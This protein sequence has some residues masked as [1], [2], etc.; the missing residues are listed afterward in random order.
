LAAGITF[1]AFLIEL[2]LEFLA[3][4]VDNDDFKVALIAQLT[5]NCLDCKCGLG[6]LLSFFRRRE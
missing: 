6:M 5:V 2:I 1:F 3:I 4:V